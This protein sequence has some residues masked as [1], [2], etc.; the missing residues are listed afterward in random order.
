MGVSRLGGAVCYGL[1][2]GRCFA[3]AQKFSTLNFAPPS[4]YLTQNPFLFAYGFPTLKCKNSVAHTSSNQRSCRGKGRIS[5][6]IYV[7]IQKTQKNFLFGNAKKIL[8]IAG[9]PLGKSWRVIELCLLSSRQMLKTDWRYF[10]CKQN[11]M[12]YLSKS[13]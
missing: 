10:I 6:V 2:S 9:I 7:H 12:D 13:R 3:L 1:L 8:D 5:S 4:A 11:L